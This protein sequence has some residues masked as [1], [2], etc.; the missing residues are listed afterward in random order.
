MYLPALGIKDAAAVTLYPMVEA[1]LI[2][3]R[4]FIYNALACDAVL[5]FEPLPLQPSVAR[6]E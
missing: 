4:S 2:D 5:F 6:L 1:V 3:G